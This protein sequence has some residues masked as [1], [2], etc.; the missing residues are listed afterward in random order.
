M[1]KQL[2]TRGKTTGFTVVELVIVIVVI[3]ILAAVTVVAY[4]GIQQ[5]AR[6]T[7][8][9][10]DIDHMD[11]A[12]AGYGLRN[13]GKAKPYFSGTNAD[14]PDLEFTP[15]KGT[16]IDVVVVDD[17]YCIRG[18]NPDGL[19]KTIQD[20]FTKESSPGFCANN[21]PSVAAG[22]T[23]PVALK[24]PALEAAYYE[25]WGGMSW[26]FTI[27]EDKISDVRA[28][29]TCPTRQTTTMTFLNPHPDAYFVKTSFGAF[30]NV[31]ENAF[32]CSLLE[33]T[34]KIDYKVG[35]EWSPIL[36]VVGDDFE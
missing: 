15:S 18:Y 30:T 1:N 2:K 11:S 9:Q 26:T 6:D 36:Y 32:G 17:N 23:A 22:G 13:G 19:K 10:S 16:I 5:R 28:I 21:G 14:D 12:Q 35:N 33:A 3:G 29:V 4:T 34:T 31:L 20:A 7:G 27:P 24:A 25:V 8:V